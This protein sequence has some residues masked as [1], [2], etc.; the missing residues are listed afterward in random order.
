M[1]GLAITETVLGGLL[2]II[3]FFFH[4][5]TSETN[6]SRRRITIIAAG[7]AFFFTFQASL[8]IV[9][10]LRWERPDG[11]LIEWL[12]PVFVFVKG[13]LLIAGAGVFSAFQ[14]QDV[15]IAALLLLFSC[16]AWLAAITSSVA[17]ARWIAYTYMVIAGF[18]TI[19][20]LFYASRR[21]TDTYHYGI[22][23]LLLLST[24]MLAIIIG[25]SPAMYNWITLS[26]QEVAM[27][28]FNVVVFLVITAIMV[29]IYGDLAVP[30]ADKARNKIQE[31]EKKFDNL[32]QR[33]QQPDYGYAN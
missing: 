13:S 14:L 5:Q 25:L 2:F 3:C 32:V 21:N 4:K 31:S 6:S 27:M 33:R 16:V 22:Y 26:G 17:D 20:Y 15:V 1:N 24:T 10:D 19:M 11:Q 28:I 29:I 12:N 7:V 8:D 9:R 30:I 18:G 23:V